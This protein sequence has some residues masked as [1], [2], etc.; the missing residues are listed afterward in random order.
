M[1]E[2][3][4]NALRRWRRGRGLSA[5]AL[6]RRLGIGKSTLHRYELAPARDNARVPG[7]Q[8]MAMIWIVSGG[9]VG[10]GCFYDL[11]ELEH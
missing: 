2:N 7:R 6:A 10:P 8:A 1:V 5:G 3:R 9:E 11:P 4:Y